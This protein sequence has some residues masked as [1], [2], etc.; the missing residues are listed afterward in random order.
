MRTLWTEDSVTFDGEFYRT[1][2]AT[3]YDK[4]DRPVPVYV[5]AGG[6]VVAKYAGRVGDGFICTSGKGMELY[7]DK[8]LPAV[9]EGAEAAGRDPAAVDRTIEIKMSYDRDRERALENCRFWAP[10]SLSAEQKHSVNSATEMERLADELPIEQVARAG[11]SHRIRTRRSRRSAV[12]RRGSRTTWCSTVRATTRSGS[13][14]SSPTTCCP[15]CADWPLPPL[16]RR[17]VRYVSAPQPRSFTGRRPAGPA[18]DPVPSGSG[19]GKVYLCQRRFRSFRRS[20]P[21]RD[22]PFEFRNLR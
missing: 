8:L 20:I 2:D 9:A 21:A 12:R 3:V 15:S 4:P 10:L 16:K 19:V 11:S 7:T 13:S 1:V 17:G 5:A 14:R 18:A 22:Q 6:P